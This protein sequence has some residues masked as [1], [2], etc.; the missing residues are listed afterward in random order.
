MCCRRRCTHHTSL[1]CVCVC[2]CA[3]V[4]VGCLSAC[5]CGGA[6][7]VGLLA[8]P[9][10]PWSFFCLHAPSPSMQTVGP[11][12]GP[13]DRHSFQ[14]D[15]GA[16]LCSLQTLPAGPDFIFETPYSDPSPLASSM[17][18]GLTGGTESGSTGPPVVFTG[19]VAPGGSSSGIT[20]AAAA[21]RLDASVDPK[22]FVLP[23]PVTRAPGL[24]TSC[25]GP[26]GGLRKPAPAGSFG[27][28]STGRR[29]CDGATQ[30]A[31]AGG[32]AGTA[33]ARIGF[34]SGGGSGSSRFAGQPP[35]GLRLPLPL[36]HAPPLTTSL[37]PTSG[38]GSRGLGGPVR[39]GC[40]VSN[41]SLLGLSRGGGLSPDLGTP[42]VAGGGHDDSLSRE[43]LSPFQPPSSSGLEV[44][45]GDDGYDPGLY[46]PPSTLD[47]QFT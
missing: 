7:P 44:F 40:D 45:L 10:S 15:D 20:P 12:P 34:L 42:T 19:R 21:W 39:L 43:T 36:S 6:P 31:G 22:P 26:G 16:T 8:K 24:G 41:C 14:A 25:A 9:H 1:V 37:S 29:P 3:C 13:I 5:A 11:G 28:D 23:T 46:F 2:A 27:G 4:C 18:R 32:G 17:H 33:G 35:L 30:G 38:L 47:A